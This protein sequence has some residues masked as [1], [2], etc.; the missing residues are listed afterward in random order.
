VTARG[1]VE[2]VAGAE[3]L[4]PRRCIDRRCDEGVRLAT[5]RPTPCQVKSFNSL[6][7]LLLTA[8]ASAGM[9]TS[10]PWRLPRGKSA[11]SIGHSPA[12]QQSVAL[13][14]TKLIGQKLSS[15]AIAEAAMRV[16]A[17]APRVKIGFGAP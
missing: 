1:S 13:D 8:A 9:T 16:T 15:Q 5:L 3:Q 12:S 2:T 7:L 6:T 14:R 11:D 4:C 17:G 10:S